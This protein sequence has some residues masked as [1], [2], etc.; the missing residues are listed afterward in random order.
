MARAGRL[1]PLPR[2]SGGR[3]APSRMTDHARAAQHRE[4]PAEGGGAAPAGSRRSTESFGSA[5]SA[6]AASAAAAASESDA[7]CPESTRIGTGAEAHDA[8]DRLEPGHPRQLD[9]H[10]DEIGSESRDRRDRLLRRARH[11]DDVEL[12]V[13]LDQRAGARRRRSC[14]SSQMSTR[15]RA[16]SR[17]AP[18]MRAT[19]SSS[20]CWSKLSLTM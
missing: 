2:S 12:A 15:G 7:T 19:V 20:A 5:S 1:L 10:R 3:P 6:P 14:E 4:A 8:L 18:T 9:V 13:V 16:G 17:H 11:A